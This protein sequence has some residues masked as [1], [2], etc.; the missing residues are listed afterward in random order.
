MAS[1]IT[2][3]V[4]DAYDQGC[5]RLDVKLWGLLPV[6]RARGPLLDR[7]EIQRYLAELV[8]CPMALLHNPDINFESIAED[9]VRV[10]VHDPQTHV[11]LNF[12]DSG[13]IVGARTTTRAR[14]SILQP[15][16][17]RFYDY[18]DY[19]GIRAPSRGEVWWE[20]EDGP[21]VYWRGFVTSLAWA[22]EPRSA[23]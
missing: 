18:R 21:F 5:G 19:D 12:D 20:T 8:W 3:V 1:L 7:G 11:D 22:S 10:W 9:V 4:E 16:E 13:D 17:G 14:G 23:P 15:W 2:A 6:V